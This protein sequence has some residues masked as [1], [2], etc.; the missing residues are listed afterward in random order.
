MNAHPAPT[1]TTSPSLTWSLATRPAATVAA[2]LH[3]TLE[4]RDQALFDH[5]L[6]VGQVL[7]AARLGAVEGQRDDR[8]VARDEHVVAGGGRARRRGRNPG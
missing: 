4:G 1:A 2:E 8:P 5:M 3:A 6:F 7:R